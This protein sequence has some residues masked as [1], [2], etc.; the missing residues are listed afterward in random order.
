M[1]NSLHLREGIRMLH[2]RLIVA[3]HGIKQ[4]SGNGEQICK[5]II[6]NCWNGTFFQ[7]S[8]GHFPVFYMRDFGM[9]VEALLKLGYKKEVEKTLQFALVVYSRENKISTTISQKG[10]GFDVFSYAPD[11]LAFLLRSLRIAKATELVEIYKLFLEQQIQFFYDNVIVK[12]TGLV[13]KDKYFSSI[14][15]HAKRQSCCYDNCC[16]A[17]IAREAVLLQLE[18]PFQKY[19]YKEIIKKTFWTGKYFRDSVENEYVAGDANVFPYWFG[20]FTEKAMMKKSITAMQK[21]KLDQPFPLKYTNFVPKQFI[22]PLSLLTSNYEG[23]SIWAHL[24]LCYIDVAAKVNKNVAKKYVEQYRKQIEQHKNF[25]E[26]Y[27]FDGKPYKT[28][29][30]YTDAG[31]LWAVKWRALVRGI[32]K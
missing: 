10:N 2:R 5:Q 18:N 24:G 9:C 1:Y 11:S 14:K 16:A 4:Y 13:R 6:Q 30:Y 15:D 26:L 19:N 23:T 31:M 8:I 20:I 7:V 25:L 28:P 3:M 27:D 29:F 22:F 17:I 12:K 32:N 21:E